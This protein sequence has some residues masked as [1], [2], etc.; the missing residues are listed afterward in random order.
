VAKVF[1]VESALKSGGEE[2]AKWSHEGRKNGHDEK[3]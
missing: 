2:A 3:M 1:D